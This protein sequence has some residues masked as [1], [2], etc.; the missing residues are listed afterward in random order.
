[1]TTTVLLVDPFVEYDLTDV[2]TEQLTE[3]KSLASY[4][5][6][7][8]IRSAL[9]DAGFDLSSGHFKGARRKATSR[10]NKRFGEL[11]KRTAKGL[12]NMT[13]RFLNDEITQS[14]WQ[15]FVRHLLREGYKEAFRLGFESSGA[16]D[17]HAR[18]SS[19]DERWIASASRAEMR[20]FNKLLRQI[21]AT[22]QRRVPATEKIVEIVM[23]TS[24][25]RKKLTGEATKKVKKKVKI[26][27][28][29]AQLTT[30]S[31]RYI[32]RRMTAYADTL[33]HAYYA[34]RVKGT[35][36]GMVI[37]WISPLDR[38][39]CKGCRYMSEH[40][41]WTRDS[42]PT[43]P[44]AGDT[45]CLSNCRCR[46]VMREVK[47]EAYAALDK[48]KRPKRWYSTILDRLRAA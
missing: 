33:K 2:L 29:P 27:A 11:H 17:F 12:H 21:V 40:S 45:R 24:W 4:K 39:T 25:L 43:T 7:G 38:H 47:R 3:G 42:L 34:G 41:P 37:D 18:I 13:M 15:V 36:K 16:M 1:M 35:P 32:R 30:N 5:G 23:P 8:E 10:A 28:K 19:E 20:H 26:P 22:H 48:R 44:R 6:T 9:I 46:L 14:R 31:E